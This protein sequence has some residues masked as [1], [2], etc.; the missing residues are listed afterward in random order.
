MPDKMECSQLTKGAVWIREIHIAGAA[1]PLIPAC[2]GCE[3][4]CL[5][6]KD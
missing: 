2:E 1:G 4:I 3:E 5:A 6:S